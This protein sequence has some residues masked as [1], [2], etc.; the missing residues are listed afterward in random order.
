[1]SQFSLGSAASS[2]VE[3]AGAAAI[4]TAGAP[5]AGPAWTVF[6]FVAGVA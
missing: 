2:A 1:V 6:V 5:A 3:K 4:D